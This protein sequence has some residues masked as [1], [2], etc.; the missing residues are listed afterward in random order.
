MAEAADKF[1]AA[2]SGGQQQRVAIARALANDPAVLLADEPTGN[3]DSAT[4]DAVFNL[5]HGRAAA[6]RTV[7]IVTHDGEIASRTNRIIHLVDG[8]V[9]DGRVD[10]RAVDSRSP[11]GFDQTGG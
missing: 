6:G 4:A 10:G 1:P 7:A 9:V 8:R 11:R 2:L 3:L 5:L